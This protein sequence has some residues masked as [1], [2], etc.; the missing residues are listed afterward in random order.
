MFMLLQA[1]KDLD[2]TALLKQVARLYFIGL[3]ALIL[4]ATI[5]VSALGILWVLLYAVCWVF[6]L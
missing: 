3:G 4:A 1:I 5:I 2:I 6:D